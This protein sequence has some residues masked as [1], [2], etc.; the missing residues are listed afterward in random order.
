MKSSFPKIFQKK[1]VNFPLW[2]APQLQMNVVESTTLQEAHQWYLCG[3]CPWW[4]L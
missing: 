3:S 4:T 2:N 1:K